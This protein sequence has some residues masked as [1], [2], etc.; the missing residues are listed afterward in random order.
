MTVFLLSKRR[1]QHS[2]TLDQARKGLPRLRSLMLRI[3]LDS[4]EGGKYRMAG[5]NTTPLFLS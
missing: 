3:Q 5:V 2:T 4:P 1:R